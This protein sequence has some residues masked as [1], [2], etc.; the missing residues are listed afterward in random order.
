MK[1]IAALVVGFVLGLLLADRED[2]HRHMNVLI[3]DG[4]RMIDPEGFEI[5]TWEE[6]P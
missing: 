4:Y 2:V 5:E 1:T 6:L 3:A